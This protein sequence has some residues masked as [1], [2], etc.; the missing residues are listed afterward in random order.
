MD[1]II[2]FI[3]QCKKAY[4]NLNTPFHEFKKVMRAHLL[5]TAWETSKILG[6]KKEVDTRIPELLSRRAKEP[7]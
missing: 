4:K 5:R 3:K 6:G 2:C 1:G 7:H